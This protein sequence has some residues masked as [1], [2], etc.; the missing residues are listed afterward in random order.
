MKIEH[1]ESFAYPED[2]TAKLKDE[3]LQP[4]KD[5]KARIRLSDGVAIEAAAFELMESGTHQMHACVS[6]QAGCKFGC[7]F[8]E[9]GKNGF[10][11]DLSS[12]EIVQEIELLSRAVGKDRLDHVVYMGI[13]E[14]LDNFDNV[15]ASIRTLTSDAWYEGKI[16]LA[17]V[18]I[19]ALLR[20]LGS[21]RLPLRMI[22]VSLHAA[23]SEKRARI[24]P[25][26]RAVSVEDTV[27]AA[28][29][30]ARATSTQTWIN[31]MIL[32]GF[33]NSEADAKALVALLANAAEELSVMLT[34][35]NGK[36]EGYESGDMDD[37]RRFESV[38]RNLGMRNRIARFYAAG[39]S[40]QAG[41]GEF[42][43]YPEASKTG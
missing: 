31:Y 39:R 33:N 13:G 30:F 16:S 21:E 14:P 19:P 3:V 12:Q 28:Q 9:S 25:V 26:G 6:T 43:F 40:V 5:T 36:V 27:R 2:L 23:S 35:P 42:I 10:K 7:C 32:R 1:L 34:I 18:G 37:V 20:R 8:C 15:V 4:L 24:M 38:L 22:W 29:E 11:R 41:C 17:T